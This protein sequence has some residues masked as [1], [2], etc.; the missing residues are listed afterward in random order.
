MSCPSPCCRHFSVSCGPHC[1]RHCAVPCS[2]ARVYP[3]LATCLPDCSL[4]RSPPCGLHCSAHCPRYCA[5]LTL[6]GHA[7]SLTSQ[8]QRT[9]L[10]AY[11]QGL[12][13]GNSPALAGC[14]ERV[15]D[16]CL[17]VCHDSQPKTIAVPVSLVFSLRLS[18]IALRL[19]PFSL[20]LLAEIQRNLKELTERPQTVRGVPFR[21]YPLRGPERRIDDESDYTALR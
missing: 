15:R 13:H 2:P 3:R 7:S 4:H 9:R 10:R 21:P 5:R 12:G 8:G 19:S 6:G 16:E 17:H 20:S 1:P 11:G 14:F 18:S